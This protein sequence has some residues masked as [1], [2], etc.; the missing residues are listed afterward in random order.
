MAIVDPTP[1]LTRPRWR[2]VLVRLPAGGAAALQSVLPRER[3][4]DL[5]A[6][7][8][9]LR[10]V[11]NEEAAEQTARRLRMVGAVVALLEESAPPEHNPYCQDHVTGLASRSCRS[12]KRAICA[13]CVIRADNQPLCADC[14]R[15]TQVQRRQVRAR[16]LFAV[17][18]FAVFLFEVARWWREQAESVNPEGVVTVG[19]YQFVPPGKL[20][21]PIVRQMNQTGDAAG[22]ALRDI[23]AW[24]AAERERYTG[25]PGPYLRLELRGPWVQRVEP[26]PLAG[27]ED[28]WWRVGLQSWRYARYFSQLPED[29]GVNTDAVAV[30]VY[31]IYGD[32]QG[33]LAAHSRGSEKGRL[34]IAFVA[35]NE[36]NPAYALT[37]VAHELAHTLGARDLYDEQSSVALYPEGFVEPFATPLYPQRYAELM[38]VDRPLGPSAEAEVTSL[39]EVRVGYATAA[40]LGW[41]G[42]EQAVWYYDPPSLKAEEALG[43]TAPEPPPS[44]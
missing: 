33:D 38:A 29:R 28:P 15:R 2:V 4:I 18:L 39:A 25:R 3:T 14:L 36:R 35:L 32:A 7:P 37:T 16:Q 11:D 22:M 44:D 24:F 42:A 27:P 17:F 20:Q 41:I 9:V 43:G 40:D 8:M 12:C 34:A 31:V 19:I 23:G 21:A 26:P 30:R 10:V 13:E 5:D 1:A 6:L